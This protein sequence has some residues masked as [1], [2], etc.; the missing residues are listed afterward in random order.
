EKRSQIGIAA[1]DKQ[2]QSVQQSL[3]FLD[4]FIPGELCREFSATF[5]A[6]FGELGR[7]SNQQR[8]QCIHIAPPDLFRALQSGHEIDDALEASSQRMPGHTTSGSDF[9][10]DRQVTDDLLDL[11][12]AVERVMPPLPAKV[13]P[14]DKRPS[15]I[16]KPVQRL[17]V[18]SRSLD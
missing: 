10:Q 3:C 16:T 13:T 7:Q 17:I 4:H 14:L 11:L 12:I 6:R 15:R 8:F 1:L 5:R 2:V 18:L 9:C